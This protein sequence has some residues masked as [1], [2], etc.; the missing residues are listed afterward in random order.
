LLLAGV[1]HQSRGRTCV[2]LRIEA[3]TAATATAA[4][5]SRETSDHGTTLELL[6]VDELDWLLV[7]EETEVVCVMVVIE[8][9]EVVEVE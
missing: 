8:E 3:A 1:S 9:M 2:L 4:T 7:T 5:A 6:P